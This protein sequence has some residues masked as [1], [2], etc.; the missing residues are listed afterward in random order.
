MP[1]GGDS[2]ELSE[3]GS[4]TMPHGGDNSELSVLRRLLPG[5]V[6]AGRSS[7][8]SGMEPGCVHGVVLLLH[9]WNGG[10]YQL[11]CPLP[12]TSGL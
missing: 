6:S 11:G 5:S 4:P 2:S 9:G 1:H 12:P 8:P 7:S 10:L 3:L